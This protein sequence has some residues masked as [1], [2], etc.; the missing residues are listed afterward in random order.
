VGLVG[1]LLAAIG[2]YGSHG[3]AW[4]RGARA[5]W[6]FGS[7]WA[8]HRADVVVEDPASGD[9]ARGGGSAIGL[10]LAPER[11]VCCPRSVLLSAA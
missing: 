11:A 7:R 4:T 10:I 3:G 8:P 6:V 9:D 2:I 5:R 1:L